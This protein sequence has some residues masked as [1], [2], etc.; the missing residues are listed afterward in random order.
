MAQCIACLP[1][2]SLVCPLCVP[3]SLP[4][5]IVGRQSLPP[6]SR[7][8]ALAMLLESK[9]PVSKLL[10]SNLGSIRLVTDQ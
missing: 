8:R 1:C 7:R 10:R 6:L 2:A 4:L 9:L 5:Y 3:P